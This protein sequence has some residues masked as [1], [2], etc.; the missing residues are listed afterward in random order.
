MTDTCPCLV[1]EDPKAETWCRVKDPDSG[2]ICSLVP[3]HPGDHIACDSSEHGLARW[4]NTQEGKSM[5]LQT[6]IVKLDEAISRVNE[7]SSYVEEAKSKAED[8]ENE[9]YTA[10]CSASNSE[11]FAENAKSQA[12]NAECE[13]DALREELDALRDALQTQLSSGGER[14]LQADIEKHKKN[15]QQL[16]SAGV[17]HATIAKKLSISEFLVQCIEDHLKEAA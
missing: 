17:S 1:G 9:A 11:D 16:L 14:S 13:L 10:R 7:A 6:I 3:G 2:Y 8:A 15:V 4:T 5:D 12:Y